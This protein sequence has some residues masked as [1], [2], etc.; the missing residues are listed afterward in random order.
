MT[1]QQ[2]LMK[3]I[4]AIGRWGLLFYFFFLIALTPRIVALD[5]TVHLIKTLKISLFTLSSS[6]VRGFAFESD[7]VGKESVV[8]NLL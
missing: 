4:N 2:L 7:A 1:A 8:Q 3:A 6:F 5:R